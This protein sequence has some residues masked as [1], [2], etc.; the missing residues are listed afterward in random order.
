MLFTFPIF[1]GIILTEIFKKRVAYAIRK[2]VGHSACF[3]RRKIYRKIFKFTF[4]A[5]LSQ[6]KFG[7]Y[8]S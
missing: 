2:S 4:G 3:E 8:F 1:R 5:G 7:N 6:R